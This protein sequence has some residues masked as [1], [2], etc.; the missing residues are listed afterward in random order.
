M[1]DPTNQPNKQSASI[2]AAQD[3]GTWQPDRDPDLGAEVEQQ[4]AD[5]PYAFAPDADWQP[6]PLLATNGDSVAVEE[7]HADPA[8][9]LVMRARP[10]AVE[11]EEHS[12]RRFNSPAQANNQG[13][14]SG[15][16]V[17]AGIGLFISIF[18]FHEAGIMVFVLALLAIW[19]IR[20]LNVGAQ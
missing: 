2:T 7:Y 18:L 4:H 20:T 5:L 13:D 12:G 11:L 17:F 19:L 10:T 6:V 1:P 9:E 15:W 14:P 8:Q 16:V 3:E